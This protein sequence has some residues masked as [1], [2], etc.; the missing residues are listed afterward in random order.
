MIQQIVDEN[1]TLRHIILSALNSSGNSFSNSTYGTTTGSS[2]PQTTAT[3]AAAAVSGTQYCCCCN[4]TCSTTQC[5]ITTPNVISSQHLVGQTPIS[6]P[7]SQTYV[8]HRRSNRHYSANTSNKRTNYTNSGN[9][10]NA[11]YY[12]STSPKVN[13][14]S[15]YGSS[16]LDN[17]KSTTSN[18]FNRYL[19]HDVTRPPTTTLY[20]TA[21]ATTAAAAAKSELYNNKAYETFSCNS[22][23]ASQISNTTLDQDNKYY[24]DDNYSIDSGGAH[25]SKRSTYENANGL[26]QDLKG[27]FY[28]QEEEVS[29]Q[30]ECGGAT[31]GNDFPNDTSEANPDGKP[32][33]ESEAP[34]YNELPETKVIPNGDVNHRRDKSEMFLETNVRSSNEEC[35]KDQTVD[36]ESQPINQPVVESKPVAN[37]NI[38]HYEPVDLDDKSDDT[39]EN[40]ENDSNNLHLNSLQPQQRSPKHLLPK[41]EAINL[42]S[43]QL[44][45]TSVRLK[46]YLTSEQ[47]PADQKKHYIVDMLRAKP[48]DSPNSKMVHQGH[49][50]NCRILHLQPLQ[51]YTFRVRT[52]TDTAVLLSNLLTVVTPEPA[53]VSSKGTGRKSKQQLQQ[54]LLQQQQQII[55]Q[56]QLLQQHYH[57]D[58][59]HHST[60]DQ[61]DSG[62]LFTPALSTDQRFAL[63]ILLGFTFFA[64]IMAVFI[65]NLLSS[66]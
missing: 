57:Q 39:D 16:K 5:S 65:Q 42:T 30:S 14:P 63:L 47:Q 61:C 7:L 13:S 45:P 35:N 43:S 17:L 46:W 41:I 4:N 23:N 54:Q 18:H 36:S 20:A 31:T 32:K 29:S 44:T 12:S 52:S 60:A 25:Y 11:S 62:G 50:T 49:T 28:D 26:T 21:T 34:K 8:R 56:Q 33:L 66:N 37:G 27:C 38:D 59:G 15:R 48:D 53:L 51:E 64:L 2:Q 6:L 55:Q 24:K 58:Q 1:G 10:N 19:G 9:T 22:S 3:V 40:D